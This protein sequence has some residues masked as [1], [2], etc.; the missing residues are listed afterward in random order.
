MKLLKPGP[1]ALQYLLLAVILA[2]FAFF[3]YHTYH[4]MEDYAEAG[5]KPK[6]PPPPIVTPQPPAFHNFKPDDPVKYALFTFN[7]EKLEQKKPGTS[8]TASIEPQKASANYTILGVVKRDKLFLV[9]RMNNDKK[10][11]L[12]AERQSINGNHRVVNLQTSFVVIADK[13]D[14]SRTHKIFKMEPIKE[15]RHDNKK[16]L[17]RKNNPKK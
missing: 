5:R 14:R 8:A 13:S 17:K 15:I 4:T 9:V 7:K 2:V 1:K 16:Q 12:I 10:I 3:F 11:R 6:N